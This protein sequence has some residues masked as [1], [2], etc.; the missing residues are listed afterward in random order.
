M[1]NQK[2]LSSKKKKPPKTISLKDFCNLVDLEQ[3]ERQSSVGEG[4]RM[5]RGGSGTGSCLDRKDQRF[6]RLVGSQRPNLPERLVDWEEDGRDYCGQMAE[7]ED[8]HDTGLY[9]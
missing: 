9:G 4:E 3:Q 1:D 2:K 5:E 7:C 6:Q 8:C